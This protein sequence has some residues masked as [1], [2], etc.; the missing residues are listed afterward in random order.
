M[1]AAGKQIALDQDTHAD[2]EEIVRLS[3]QVGTLTKQKIAGIQ[4]ITGRTKILALNALIEA[5]RAG[6]AGKGFSVVA[7]EVKGISAEVEAIATALDQE[8]AAQTQK[9]E[10]LGRR[11]VSQIKGDRLIDLSLN[12]IE[13]IDRNLYERTCDVRWWATD[14]AVV[15]AAADPTEPKRRFCNERLGVILNSYTAYLDIWVCDVQGKVL[16]NGRPERYP[17]VAGAS[18]A[19][20]PWFQKGLNTSSGDDFAVVDVA[21]VGLLGGA[22]TATYATA[23]RDEGR[24][25]GAPIGVM[26]VHFDWTPQAQAIVDGVRL[27][28]EERALTRVLLLDSQHRVIASS[29]KQGVLTET[30]PLRAGGKDRGT[31]QDD[32]GNT[33]GFSIT[34]GYET[35]RGLGW[36]GC[37]VQQSR[38]G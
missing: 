20:E 2:P 9:L 11:I 1:A 17:R 33:V 12:A 14:A 37:I 18:V 26:A 13:I 8:L 6:E 28:P 38:K 25:N 27:T 3:Q 21:S 31:Y 24:A 7:A 16:S 23:I 5:A 19:H 35:Y 10:R 29:D 34:P 4:Q 15:D 22:A 30:F 36:Y 32:Q